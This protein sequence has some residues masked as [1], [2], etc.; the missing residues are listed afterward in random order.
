MS[1]GT[2]MFRNTG[3]INAE[4]AA[5]PHLVALALDEATAILRTRILPRILTQ[6]SGHGAVQSNREEYHGH[7]NYMQCSSLLLHITIRYFPSLFILNLLYNYYITYQS[8]SLTDP[9]IFLVFILN[10]LPCF[11]SSGLYGFC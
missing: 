3:G 10:L 1:H 4:V 8:S 9:Y 2:Q 6:K 5:H 7:A 11:Y